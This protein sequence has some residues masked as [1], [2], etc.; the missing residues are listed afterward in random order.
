MMERWYDE[1]SL[2]I[3]ELISPSVS[4]LFQQAEN[5]KPGAIPLFRSPI[6]PT[7]PQKPSKARVQ[8]QKVQQ[9]VYKLVACTNLMQQ[10]LAKGRF[11]I[12]DYIAHSTLQ[13]LHWLGWPENCRSIA[14]KKR[15]VEY[16]LTNHGLRL[17]HYEIEKCHRARLLRCENRV[18]FLES[19][20]LIANSS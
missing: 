18:K 7:P 19:V 8:Q 9:R 13:K 17:V 3:D 12:R 1:I 20:W 2:S 4:A 15:Y 16:F 11:F 14:E 10:S 5:L 6:L